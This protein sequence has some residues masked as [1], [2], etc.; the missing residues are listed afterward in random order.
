MSKARDIADLDFNAPDIDGGNIDGAVIGGT[1]PAAGSF[2]GV[3]VSGGSQ[4]GQDY[5]YFK[6]N[7][8]SNASL[9]L[10]KDSSGADAIDFLQLRNNA[11]GLIGKI[12]G[13]GD[14]SF[15]AATFS[16]SISADG[17]VASARGSDTGTYGF[18]HEGAG[19][20]MR[21]GVP[22]ASFAY[23]ETDAN[24]G[25]NLDGNVTVPNQI[26]HSGDTD[27]YMQ[28]HAL[29][30]WRVVAG[31]YERFAIGTDVVVN[32]DSHDSDFRVESADNANMLVV[33]GGDNRVGIGGTPGNTLDVHGTARFRTGAST[34]DATVNT[35]GKGIEITGGNMRLNID[36]S[37]VINGGAYIQTRHIASAHPAAYYDLKLNPL[38]GFVTVN[39]AD[40]SNGG[41][42]VKGG[43]AFDTN[44]DAHRMDSYEQG[45][46]V[47]V[48]KS[49]STTITTAVNY[50]KYVKIGAMVYVTAFVTRNDGASLTGNISIH[51]LPFQVASGST[52]VNGTIWFDTTGTDEVATNYFVA[53]TSLFQP[54]K[55][56]ASG[57]Y[58]TADKFQN[59]RPYY[60]SGVY[61]VAI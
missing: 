17:Q 36:V 51:G 25:F 35:Y 3:N 41:L 13:D 53:S 37:N 61:N 20:Y 12:E 50:A 24:G 10:R 6:S 43:I 19:K 39:D 28:F 47:P 31:G 14:I 57:D 15:G 29:N 22:N 2:S 42:F 55:V 7:S 59:G 33:D 16:S 48:T 4:L 49:G 56:G 11:N 18:R 44:N 34:P 9:T 38:G 1:T 23:F 46:W 30:E 54:K 40:H 58:V 21:M 8:T 27:T 52:H 5:A 45:N 26:I 32:E 60:M